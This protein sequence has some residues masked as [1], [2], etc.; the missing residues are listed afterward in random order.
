MQMK[1]WAICSDI[2]V[3]CLSIQKEPIIHNIRQIKQLEACY[4]AR[5]LISCAICR[6]SVGSGLNRMCTRIRLRALLG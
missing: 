5:F 6:I 4:C 1:I 3:H 2:D